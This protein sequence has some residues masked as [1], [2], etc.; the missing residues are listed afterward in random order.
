MGSARWRTAAL[1]RRKGGMVR[2]R[3]GARMFMPEILGVEAGGLKD[4]VEWPH[5]KHP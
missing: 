4:Q 3:H 5:L 2:G 1:A